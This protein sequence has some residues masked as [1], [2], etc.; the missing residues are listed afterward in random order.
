MNTT[1]AH[2]HQKH[3]KQITAIIVCV[4]CSSNKKQ[5]PD[6]NYLHKDYQGSIMSI[7]A[8][9]GA[10]RHKRYDPWGVRKNP[11]TWDTDFSA[12]GSI[13]A[14]G[15]TMHSLFR[16]FGKHLDDFGLIN[17]NGRVY[18]PLLGRFL[19]PDNHIQSP[20]N[21]Q[22]YNRYAYALN[23][24]LKYTDPSGE[25][26]FTALATFIPGL[27]PL[28]PVAMSMDM[29]SFTGAAR[30]DMNGGNVFEGY[31]KGAATG[32]VGGALGQIGGAGM[33][34]AKNLA[35]G[36]T[37]GA[38]VGAF[39]AWI[40]GNDIGKGMLGGAIGGAVFTT[41]ESE[42]FSNL[43]KRG[44]FLTNSNL[45]DHMLENGASKQD[46][47]DY[48][49]GEGTYNP[50]GSPKGGGKYLG[51]TGASSGDIEF[52]DDAFYKWVNNK[53]IPSYDNFMATYTKE[54]FSSTRV[55]TG[56]NETFALANIDPNLSHMRHYPEEALGFLHAYKNQG[57]YPNSS[58]NLINQANAYWKGC[59]GENLY[60]QKWYDFI[61]EIPRRY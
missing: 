8:E 44:E 55:L 39:D 2:S 43:L 9:S 35:Y 42:N 52:G 45:F 46:I 16:P 24:P 36:V 28:I 41:L 30:A 11:V 57:L 38:A 27:Q 1:E 53:R 29:A 18:D 10:V 15:Y 40:W 37:E 50:N 3:S 26:I 48:F 58:I 61:F 25:V 34:F 20:D 17:M 14:R 6:D 22:N 60:N 49:I 47:I 7:T 19:S 13:T 4:V 5:I 54:R 21:P 23:N 31:A 56:S 12:G 32:L 51:S 33:S 59:Y